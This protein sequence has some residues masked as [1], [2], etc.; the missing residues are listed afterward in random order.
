MLYHENYGNFLPRADFVSTN[1]IVPLDRL[2][3]RHQQLA[4]SAFAK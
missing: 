1:L 3:I 4:I 2:L